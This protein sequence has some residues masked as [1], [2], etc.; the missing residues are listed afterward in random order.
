MPK[1]L[2]LALI[3]L[4]SSA[5][6][7]LVVVTLRRPEKELEPYQLTLRP[8]FSAL[9]VEPDWAELE[10]YQNTIPRDVFVDQLQRVYSQDDAW[11][12]N[13]EVHEGHADLRAGGNSRMRLDF[14]PSDGIEPERYWRA[15]A[16]LPVVDDLDAKP[17]QGLKIAI[18]P[19]HIGGEWAKVEERWYQIGG[20]GIEVMEGELTLATAKVLR[21]R[22]EELGAQVWLL[23]EEHQPVT[24]QRPFDF[25]ELAKG[26]LNKA[27][28]AAEGGALAKKSEQLFYRAHEIRQRARLINDD[29][30]P[31]LALCL[32]YNAVSW[33]DPNNPQLVSSNHLHLLI[34]GTYS[35]SEF[36]LEDNRFHLFK[37]LLQRTHDEEL[38]LNEAVAA[39]MAKATG[40]SPYV[41][42]TR[43][44]KPVG[45]SGYVYARNLLANRI[46]HCPVVFLEPYVMNNQEVY[47][48]VEAGDYEGE[49]EVA[50]A[51]RKSLI[52][53]YAE[54]VAKGLRQ[55]Y[56]KARRR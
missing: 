28:I 26:V 3:L 32:H 45:H 29:I 6:V 2:R 7:A 33:G 42:F 38:P 17:L 52:R 53:E 25:I 49:R 36:R 37:R 50:G 40:L 15:A 14:A 34:N 46:Y 39:A 10:R 18:D 27:G 9:A 1:N 24:S 4:L 19:G 56:S 16:E 48:R 21:A 44:A 54:G 43:N 23:R 35:A 55:Y 12:S 8:G 30:R 31:D 11:R 22:L 47:L 41:Y 51:M 5:G 20:E 13:V